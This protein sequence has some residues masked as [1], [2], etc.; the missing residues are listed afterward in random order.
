MADARNRIESVDLAVSEIA[1]Q[2]QTAEVSEACRRRR[3]TPRGVQ[4][5]VGD[6]VL[7]DPAAGVEDVYK[8]VAGPADI[9]LKGAKPNGIPG[10]ENVP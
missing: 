8:T 4:Q 7:Q 6:Q 10:S 3:E 2:Q 1:H 5:V 9:E